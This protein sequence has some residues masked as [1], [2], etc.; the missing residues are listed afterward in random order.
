MERKGE[1]IGEVALGGDNFKFVGPRS[2]P[3]ESNKKLKVTDQTRNGIRLRVLSD[4]RREQEKPR[5]Q[6]RSAGAHA[7]AGAGAAC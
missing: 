5:S 3:G 2:F 7:G 1:E 6:R 4:V